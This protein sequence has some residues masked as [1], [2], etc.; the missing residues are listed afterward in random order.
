MVTIEVV[1]NL[2][3]VVARLA[4]GDYPAGN[5]IVSWETN[6]VLPSGAYNVRLVAGGNVSTYPVMLVK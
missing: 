2:G 4:N 3:N 1:D 6:D 5:H